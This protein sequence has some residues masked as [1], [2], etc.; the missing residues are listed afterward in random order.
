MHRLTQNLLTILV[1]A[2]GYVQRLALALWLYSSL[3]GPDSSTFVV[4][5][6]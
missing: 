6:S 4:H 3:A 5:Q 1:L 2:V